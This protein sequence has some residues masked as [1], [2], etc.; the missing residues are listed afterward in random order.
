MS[1]EACN[2]DLGSLLTA[3]SF[4]WKVS[5]VFVVSLYWAYRLYQR[6]VTVGT[7]RKQLRAVPTPEVARNDD[8]VAW[9]WKRACSFKS[10]T[11]SFGV[12][13]LG[14]PKRSGLQ[15]LIEP[16]DESRGCAALARSKS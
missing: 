6:T 12:A 15:A 13:A 2:I 11:S 5:V 4:D 14:G 7:A 3:W 10:W 16:Q 9:K 8:R 1:L